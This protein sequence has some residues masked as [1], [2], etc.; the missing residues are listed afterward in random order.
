MEMWVQGVNPTHN[1]TSNGSF[2]VELA[3]I[4]LAVMI[5]LRITVVTQGI[6]LEE[7]CALR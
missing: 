1:Y 5:P 2:I 6:S 3:I 4:A 7:L